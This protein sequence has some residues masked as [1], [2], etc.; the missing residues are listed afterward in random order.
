MPTQN[1]FGTSGTPTFRSLYRAQQEAPDDVASGVLADVPDPALASVLDA[2]GNVFIGDLRYHFGSTEAV[3]YTAAGAV[4]SRH[5]VEDGPVAGDGS[6]SLAPT[7]GCY[8]YGPPRPGGPQ[9]RICGET[10]NRGYFGIYASQGSRSDHHERRS[11][12]RGW[13]YADTPAALVEV[14][15]FD[16]NNGTYV[17]GTARANYDT[18]VIYFD[19]GPFGTGN[20]TSGTT[21][22]YHE[23]N[24]RDYNGVMRY[25][26]FTTE[27]YFRP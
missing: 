23:S 4:A 11:N 3:A 2:S 10:W 26:T 8:P 17:A 27:R 21:R 19:R 25:G 6:S 5:P 15:C 12:W 22:C 16:A 1:A 13:H 14:E 20:D 9:F 18:V 24:Q 7:E